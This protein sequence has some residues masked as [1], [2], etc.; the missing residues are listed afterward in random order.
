MSLSPLLASP[1]PVSGP[2]QDS[3]GKPY[4]SSRHL[5]AAVPPPCDSLVVS[6]MPQSSPNSCISPPGLPPHAWGLRSPATASIRVPEQP[7]WVA[8]APPGRS[9]FLP[10]CG[11][12]LGLASPVSPLQPPSSCACCADSHSSPSGQSFASFS[13]PPNSRCCP[14]FPCPLPHLVCLR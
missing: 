12:S 1:H 9:R 11:F 8:W 7:V 14:C 10:A 6:S 5:L 13:P 2:P 4:S 3:L